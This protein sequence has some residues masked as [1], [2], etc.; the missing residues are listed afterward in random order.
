MR[1]PT[2][3]FP[4]LLAFGLAGCAVPYQPMGARGGYSERQLGEGYYHVQFLGNIY[5]ERQTVETYVQYR[6]AELTVAAGYAYFKMIDGRVQQIPTG[7]IGQNW[8]GS[9]QIRMF[10]GQTPTD[11]TSALDAKDVL[12][13]LGP[14]VKGG[15]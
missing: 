14:Q 11:D 12:R 9:A 1:L 15:S 6:C 5:T 4:V 10:K 8:L 3:V 7:G 2:K 13:R